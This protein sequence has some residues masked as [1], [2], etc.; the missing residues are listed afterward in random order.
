MPIVHIHI[1]AG[2]GPAEKKAILDGVH[3]ALVEAFKIPEHD[4][5]QILHEHDPENFESAHGREF[6]LVEVTAFPGRS[7]EAKARL[8]AGIVEN[9]RS[10]PGIDPAKV[11]I[12][13]HE[14]PLESWGIKCGHPASQV[15]V[16]FKLD[17]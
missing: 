15:G 16:G 5:N 14:P 4:R 17:V 10:S 13:I 8:Y 2:R 7:A 11:L 9:L 6:T 3:A 1:A 12:V